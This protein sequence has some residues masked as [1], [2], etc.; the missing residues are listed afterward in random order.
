MGKITNYNF[1]WL[2]FI[3]LIQDF[4]LDFLKTFG[5]FYFYLLL[6]IFIKELFPLLSDDLWKFL[7]ELFGSII[8]KQVLWKIDLPDIRATKCS[9]N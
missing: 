3:L 7:E 8:I 6:I 5:S 2:I 4:F 9:Q 1:N